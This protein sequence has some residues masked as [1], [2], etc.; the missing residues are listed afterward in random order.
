MKTR[1]RAGKF[2]EYVGKNAVLCTCQAAALAALGTILFL[3]A[4]TFYY[5]EKGPP[6][7]REK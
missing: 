1:K 2:R 5:Y 3:T 6:F 4:Q 7:R